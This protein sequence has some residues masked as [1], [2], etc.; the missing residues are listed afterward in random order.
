MLND[1]VKATGKVSIL[2]TDALGN[3]KDEREIDNLVVLTG[4]EFMASRMKDATATV[5]SHMAVGTDNTAAAS[6]NTNLGAEVSSSRTALTST[7]VSS[8][9]VTYACTFNPGVGTGA[10][11]EAGIFNYGT[12]TASPSASQTLLCR[13]IFAVI[14]K[15]AADTLTISWTVTIS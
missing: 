13:T 11:V 5:M 4:R 10:L 8:N 15:G 6:G 9:A 7:T 2:L 14:N 3:I 1:I 12:Y